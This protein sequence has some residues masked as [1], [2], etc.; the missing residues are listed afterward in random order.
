M[1]ATYTIPELWQQ[2]K[3]GELTAEQALGYLLQNIVAQEQR[4]TAIEK[5]IQALEHRLS[6]KP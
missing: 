2:W 4:Q 1:M 3:L 5:R 6:A